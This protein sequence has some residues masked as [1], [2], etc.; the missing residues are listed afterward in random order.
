MVEVHVSPSMDARQRSNWVISLGYHRN[1][2]SDSPSILV[3][4]GFHG[5]VN[6][7]RAQFKAKAS[8]ELQEIGPA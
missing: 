5:S 7:I 6:L 3:F 4:R 8:G 1:R 2:N